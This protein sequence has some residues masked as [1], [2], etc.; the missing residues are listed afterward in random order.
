MIVSKSIQ[1]IFSKDLI[2]LI[3]NVFVKSPKATTNL[4]DK[5]SS[6]FVEPAEIPLLSDGR[7]AA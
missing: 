6:F 2:R 1:A 4:S 5:N 7:V 3:S